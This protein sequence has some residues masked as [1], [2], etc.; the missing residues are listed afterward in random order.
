MKS[1]S[2]YSTSLPAAYEG[3]VPTGNGN[4]EDDQFVE[5]D[6]GMEEK[7]IQGLQELGIGSRHQDLLALSLGRALANERRVVALLPIHS[8]PTLGISVTEIAAQRAAFVDD[9]LAA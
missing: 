5:D 7:A 1:Y 8:S 2:S 9:L 4:E 3:A 6:S